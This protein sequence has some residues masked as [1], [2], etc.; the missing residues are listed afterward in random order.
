M[1]KL[2]LPFSF[3][4]TGR[5]TS[6]SPFRS[7]NRRCACLANVASPELVSIA[8]KV[9]L[10]VPLSPNSI[11]LGKGTGSFRLDRQRRCFPP[12]GL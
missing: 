12:S 10:R 7:S 4:V 3:I 9:N 2:A 11:V 1:V 6:S 5:V 8:V